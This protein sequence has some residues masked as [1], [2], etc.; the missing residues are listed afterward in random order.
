MTSAIV[1]VNFN[2]GAHL[3]I[4]LQ[5]IAE[6]AP[7]ARTIVIDNAS[8]DGSDRAAEKY[9]SSV[10]L[11]RN[12]GNVGFARAVNQGLAASE[13]ELVLLLNPDC[14]LRSA[15][16]ERL[17]ADMTA[18]PECAIAAPQVL[19]ADGSVQGNARGDPNIWTGLFGRSS[20]L[21]RWFPRSAVA[22]RNVRRDAGDVSAPSTEVNWVSGACMLARRAALAAVGGFDERYFLYWEDADLC[23]RLRDRGHS[24]RHVPSATVIH[25][26]GGS[27]RVVP[28][29][30]IREFHRSAY[31]YYATHVAKSAFTRATARLLLGARCRWKLIF[32][33]LGKF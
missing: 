29:L 25:S 14:Q 13:G 6:H 33:K 3:G 20:L 31:T 8:S 19:D 26:A 27:S 10:R 18:H 11:L 24:I 5:S 4:C 9:G 28:A 12:T 16:I 32:Q 23:R 17:V 30:A 15:A 1:I 22:R 7:A 2:S 21:S